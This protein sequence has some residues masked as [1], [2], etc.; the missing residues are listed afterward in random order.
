MEKAGYQ[1]PCQYSLNDSVHFDVSI[2]LQN[3]D[4]RA[5]QL[6]QTEHKIKKSHTIRILIAI[7][8]LISIIRLIH[9]VYLQYQGFAL[10]GTVLLR[11]LEILGYLYGFDSHTSRSYTKMQIFLGFAGFALMT[12]GYSCYESFHR[13]ELC[14][15]I[16][17]IISFA[18]NVILVLYSLMYSNLLKQRDHIQK[19]L[20]KSHQGQII[21]I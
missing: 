2:I 16:E 14:M 20:E 8:L 12:F 4:P 21:Q 3:R 15:L 9:D 19:S 17:N 5:I 18:L 10:H 6:Q 7:M 1:P 11:V 13:K